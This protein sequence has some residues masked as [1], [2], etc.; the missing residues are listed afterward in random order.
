L[1]EKKDGMRI[2]VN[3]LWPRGLTKEKAKVNLWLKDNA[4]STVLR[5]W[6]SHAVAPKIF[7][8]LWLEKMELIAVADI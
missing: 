1:P 8:S 5:K 6:F 2:L 3:R 7:I 4:P